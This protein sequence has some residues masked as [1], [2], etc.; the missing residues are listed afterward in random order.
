MLMYIDS[1]EFVN[2]MD[3]P[4]DFHINHSIANMHVWLIYQRLR[5]FSENKYAF[6]LRE[7]LIDAF[8]KMTNEEMESVDV[9]RKMKKIE[10]IDNYMYAIRRNFDFHFFINGKSVDNPYYKL[11]ALVWSCIFHEKVPRYSDQVMKMSEYFVQHFNY[12]K[13]LDFMELEKAAV[14]WCSYRVPFNYPNKIMKINPPLSE[15]EFEKELESPFKVKKYH[16]SF[17]R[18]EEL[19]EEN[20]K[21]TFV[22][23]CTNAFFH[24]KEKTVRQENLNLDSLNTDEKELVMYNMKRELEEMSELPSQNSSFF[25]EIKISPTQTQFSIWKRNLFVPLADQL[26]EQ[27]KRKLADI[28]E[29]KKRQAESGMVF[30]QT[31][32]ETGLH[33]IDGQ[34]KRTERHQ[35]ILKQ[36]FAEELKDQ[37]KDAPDYEKVR[38]D[39]VEREKKKVT[40]SVDSM[41]IKQK[42]KWRIW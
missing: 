17:R 23:L 39:F 29:Q 30:R 33:D 4:N 41:P 14:N 18:E 1:W 32:D 42:R 31:Q 27:A 16:Y 28:E 20:L 21:K 37:G 35:A 34:E 5:D 3:I 36:H 9:L 10:D 2:S 6:Q 38:A 24:N 15:E 13:S 7:D 19:T 22:N 40:D 26:E 11:D 8:N 12:L 25:S